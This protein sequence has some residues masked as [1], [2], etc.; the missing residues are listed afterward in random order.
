MTPL[1]AR[2]CAILLL[3]V[4]TVGCDAVTK[5]IA[6]ESLAGSPAQSFL[7]DTIRLTYAENA[8]GFLSFGSSLPDW[9]RTHVFTVSVGFLL[10]MLAVLAWRNGWQRWRTAAFALFI[11]GGASNWVDRL[12]D[13]RVVDFL[14][15]GI[16]GLRT[17]IFNVADVAIMLGAAL[18]LFAEYRASVERRKEQ[19]P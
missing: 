11:A 18:F 13:G 12:G 7:G 5:R 10:L 14:N 1:F 16:G 19:R 6:M 15:I 9:A 2:S 17:G 3:V 4:G 8:G